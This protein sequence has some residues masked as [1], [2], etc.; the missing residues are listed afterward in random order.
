MIKKYQQ[1]IKENLSIVS[2]DEV[3]DFLDKLDKLSKYY[4]EKSVEG[5]S[6]DL[7]W[8]HKDNLITIDWG[9]STY[10]EGSSETLII[11]LTTLEV[12]HTED[13][14]SVYGD[15]Q[16]EG[17]RKFNSLKEVYKE[18]FDED[19]ITNY[20]LHDPHQMIIGYR[21]KLTEPV[22]DDFDEGLEPETNIVEVIS[23]TKDGLILMDVEHG[24]TYE[25]T[26]K[27]LM[28]CEIEKVS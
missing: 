26:F 14:S 16:N 25:R 20:K 12:T 11:D 23:K 21:Y 1:F 19:I 8:E 2:D 13:T 22:Y 17:K 7:R 27:H 6:S 3:I 5:C 15:Y 18:Y 10:E 9:W 28:T 24:F 4:D